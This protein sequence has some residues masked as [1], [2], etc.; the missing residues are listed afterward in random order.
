MRE[1]FDN[2][3]FLNCSSKDK[4]AVRALAERRTRI[5]VHG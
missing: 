2:D 3:V 4:G 5:D 1:T